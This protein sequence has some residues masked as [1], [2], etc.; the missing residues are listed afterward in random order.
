MPLNSRGDL[1]ERT[2]FA[3]SCAAAHSF[4]VMWPE[5]QSSVARRAVCFALSFRSFLSDGG[6]GTLYDASSPCCCAGSVTD[7]SPFDFFARFL[8]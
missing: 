5:T 3:R 4:V 7:F 8:S 1:P 6:G 2:C